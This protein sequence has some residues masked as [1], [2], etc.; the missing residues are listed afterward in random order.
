MSAR[1]ALVLLAALAVS[2]CGSGAD[3]KAEAQKAQE[4]TPLPGS[5]AT[6]TRT[7][8]YTCEGDMPVTAFY[9]TDFDGKPEL[10]LVIAGDDYNLHPTP[11]PHGER[12]ASA[13]GAARGKG[14]I[15]WEDGDTILLQ[16]APSEQVDDPAAGVTARTCHLKPETEAPASGNA[17]RPG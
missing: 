1:L 5:K 6:V 9:G 15:W 2:A 4:L 16:Q 17:A 14:V 13:V 7:V 12:W 11:A 10:S 3:K 8:T